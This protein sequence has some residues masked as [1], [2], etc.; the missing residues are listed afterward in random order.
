MAAF[1]KAA[2][3]MLGTLPL[4]LAAC[5]GGAD[6]K[7]HQ[8]ADAP[9]GKM[10][11]VVMTCP[12]AGGAEVKL[13]TGAVFDAKGKGCD[14]IAKSAIVTVRVSMPEGE[15]APPAA[16]VAWKDGKAVFSFE[17]ERTV[18]SREARAN[19]PLDLLVVRGDFEGADVV[20]A[21]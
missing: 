12:M 18:I 8:R 11:A 21:V 9:D 3:A 15:I 13:V 2:L 16:S 10:Q 4:M 20:E 19:A 5:A 1:R 14:D 6:Q 17:G 7:V